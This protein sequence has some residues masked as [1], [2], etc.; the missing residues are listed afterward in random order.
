MYTI[1]RLYYEQLNLQSG[2][3]TFEK[4]CASRELAYYYLLP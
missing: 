3:K 1:E 2:K 4:Y